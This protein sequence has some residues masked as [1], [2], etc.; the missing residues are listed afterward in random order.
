M[1]KPVGKPN[2]GFH[3]AA[4]LQTGLDE[5]KKISD[6]LCVPRNDA[7]CEAICEKCQFSKMAVDKKEKGEIVDTIFKKNFSM[8][9]KGEYILYCIKIYRL[10]YLC[11]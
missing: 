1:S 9:R 6:F 8:Y 11:L 10:I 2:V 7:L 4:H 5:I 3:D